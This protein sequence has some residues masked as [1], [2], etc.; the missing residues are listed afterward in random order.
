[1]K[2]MVDRAYHLPLYKQIYEQ[3]KSQILVGHLL[4]G[5]RLPSERQ[6]A[7]LLDVDR[8]T[9]SNA[10]RELKA[11]GLAGSGG[12]YGTVVL[13]VHGG[14]FGLW[15]DND[16]PMGELNWDLLVN[17]RVRGMNRVT[18]ELVIQTINRRDLISFVDSWTL[19]EGSRVDDL[20]LPAE[21]IRD[22]TALHRDGPEIA[23][24]VEGLP[25][26]REA[27]GKFMFQGT[28]FCR[29]RDIV[30]TRGARHGI[31]LVANALINPGDIVFVEEPTY[32]FA[33]Q[34]FA[35]VGARFVS[36]QMTEWGMDLDMLAR[37]LEKFRPKLIYTMPTAHNPCGVTTSE[38]H[39][40]R[41]LELAGKSNVVVVEDDPLCGMTY[42][43]QVNM[44]TLKSMDQAGNVV[45]IGTFSKSISP[46]LELGWVCG[47]K[48]IVSY[49]GSILHW[50]TLVTNTSAQVMMQKFI[51][52]GDVWEYIDKMRRMDER[53]DELYR[54]MMDS[55]HVPGLRWYRASSGPYKIVMLPPGVAATELVM[56]AGER[57]VAVLPGTLFTQ[58]KE[59]GEH[60]I[61]L[62]LRHISESDI[63]RGLEILTDTIREMALEGRGGTR[64]GYDFR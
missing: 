42:D 25:G 41:L 45:F 54:A 63:R 47:H 16:A 14:H 5:Y 55:R 1:M 23:A 59:C 35:K 62:G 18:D 19:F 4:P 21:M 6:L 61:R 11:E 51:E 58:S 30:V 56:R 13:N 32:N 50:R 26:L 3:I 40:M 8:I 36:I 46:R 48:K 52:R 64:P 9:V 20:P 2:I 34:E 29:H 53:N 15:P 60:F 38:Q 44:P 12:S 31:E 49:I 33:L 22:L 27:I 24:P 39:R 7:A 43:R 28:G 57:G 17:E 37:M 10:Y